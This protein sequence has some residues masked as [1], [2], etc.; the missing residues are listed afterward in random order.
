[1]TR[2]PSYTADGTCGLQILRLLKPAI[3]PLPDWQVRLQVEGEPGFPVVRTRPDLDP[4]GAVDREERHE[5]PHHAA[6]VY[7]Y[8]ANVGQVY[9]P[10]D[11][12]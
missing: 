10:A 12:S 5:R 4:S 6:G 2:S 8:D 11:L 9:Y 1:M 3:K 7:A